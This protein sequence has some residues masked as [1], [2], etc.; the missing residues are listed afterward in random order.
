MGAQCFE[1]FG[2]IAL[3]NHAYLL[4]IIF[5]IV[6][7]S[8][9]FLFPERQFISKQQSDELSEMNLNVTFIFVVSASV[10]KF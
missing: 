7:I 4:Y 6:R 3:K 5:N 8:V 9:Q 1:L 2:A 10:C